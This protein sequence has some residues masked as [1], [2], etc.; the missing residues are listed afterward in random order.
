MISLRNDF[1]AFSRRADARIGLL[2]E[3]IQRVQDGEDVDV[4]RLLGT[5][6]PDKEKEWVDSM[7]L[8]PKQLL[9]DA[10]IY[11]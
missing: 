7:F 6:N 10:D 2:K 5:G 8:N 3:L 11:P 9:V 4:E 1:T